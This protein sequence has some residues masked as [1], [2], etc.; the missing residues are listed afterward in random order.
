MSSDEKPN[1]SL[2]ALAYPWSAVVAGGKYPVGA[3][4]REFSEIAAFHQREA[5]TLRAEHQREN[6]ALRAKLEALKEKSMSDVDNKKNPPNDPPGK[7]VAGGKYQYDA[8]ACCGG[9]SPRFINPHVEQLQGEVAMLRAKLAVLE[10]QAEMQLGR[11]LSAE[12]K[13]RE[14]REKFQRTHPELFKDWNSGGHA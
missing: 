11:A 9:V 6:E 1:D 12:A 2:G 7:L 8:G 3:G 5:A 10:Q 4:S 13:V 14:Y